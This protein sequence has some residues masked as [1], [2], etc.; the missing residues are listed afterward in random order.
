MFTEHPTAN[1]FKGFLG[2]FSRPGSSTRNARILRHLLAGCV[3]CEDQLRLLG[4][5]GSRL[6]RLVFLSTLWDEDVLGREAP[7]DVSYDVAF[8]RAQASIDAILREMPT[9]SVPVADLLAALEART[10]E[11]QFA[12]VRENPAY[13]VPQ[14][15]EKLVE[16]GHLARFSSP[17]QMLLNTRLA[18]EASNRCR[19]ENCGGEAKLADIRG[20]AWGHH[21]NA[22]RLNGNLREAEQAASSA[23]SCL[24]IG[25]GDP[26]LRALV[27]RYVGAVHMFQRRFDEATELFQEA[28]GIYRE[29]GESNELAGALINE[30]IATIYSGE[31]QIAIRLLNQAIPLIDQELEPQLLLAACHNL[32]RCYIDLDRPEQALAIY[33]EIRD[34]YKE[35]SKDLISLR[36]AWQEGQLLRDLGHPQAAETALLRARE[37]FLQRGVMYDVALVSLDLA[38]V[39]IRM[40]RTADVRQTVEATVPIFRALS[41]EREELGALLQLQ[42]V[43]DQRQ[44]AL[45]LVR[46]LNNRIQPMSREEVL[47]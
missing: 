17:Q 45:D 18:L 24:L 26:L 12:L 6:E 47:K 31:P 27:L 46:F 32:V 1:D 11:E 9:S 22:L 28:G 29:L 42:Q 8:A 38:S 41:V 44:K 23:Q 33:S 35:L 16:R 21:A 36:A 34:L 13:A 5:G 40:G 3:L 15:V 14:L 19:P 39:Y 2:G 7:T 43:A 25:T 30:A 10:E 20:L 37:G 4:W